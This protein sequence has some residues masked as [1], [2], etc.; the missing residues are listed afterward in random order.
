MVTDIDGDHMT[1]R[2]LKKV[3]DAGMFRESNI[4]D[5]STETLKDVLF[6]C[7]EPQ[8]AAL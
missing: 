5:H 4:D 1:V 7:S 3:S 8:I 2:Y 6:I